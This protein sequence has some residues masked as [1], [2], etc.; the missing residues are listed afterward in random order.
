MSHDKY[1]EPDNQEALKVA[2]FHTLN[3]LTGKFCSYSS[4]DKSEQY[5]EL[6]PRGRLVS[7]EQQCHELVQI[8]VSRDENQSE[9]SI[10]SCRLCPLL[11]LYLFYTNQRVM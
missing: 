6:S 3:Q 10:V 1:A 8:Q 7:P 2:V 5:S 9:H 11:L 4:A